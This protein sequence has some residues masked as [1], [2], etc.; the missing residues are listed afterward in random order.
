MTDVKGETLAAALVAAQSEM[1]EIPKDGTGKIRGMSKKTGKPY[2]YDYTY[3]T[4]PTIFRLTLPVL[5]KHGLA[6]TQTSEGGCL[7]TALRYEGGECLTSSLEMPSPRS[8]SPQDYGKAHSY[9]RR[10]EVNGMLGLAADDDIDADGV[11]A[12][13]PVAVDPPPPDEN[14]DKKY[15]DLTDE[16]IKRGAVA[17]YTIGNCDDSAA[18]MDVRL[19]TLLSCYGAES[20]QEIA[21]YTERRKLHS[22]L[23]ATVEQLEK[24]AEAVGE[25]GI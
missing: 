21:G 17:L 3:A 11:A 20:R 1:P 5:N 15:M 6:L 12:P 22:D 10:Y 24:D 16:L 8:M 2:E 18:E 14:T 4:L 19:K 23:K 7:I 25:A 9:Y 13:G